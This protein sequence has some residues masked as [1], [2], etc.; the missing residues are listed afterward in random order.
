[1]IIQGG[2]R[3]FVS[4]F[5]NALCHGAVFEYGDCGDIVSEKQLEALYSH[6]EGLAK[7]A[8]DIDKA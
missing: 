2:L 3:A 6:I 5:N 7:V 1:M 8:A 4:G